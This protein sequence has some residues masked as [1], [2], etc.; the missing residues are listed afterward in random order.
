MEKETENLYLSIEESKKII[1]KTIK[2]GDMNKMQSIMGSILYDDSSFK[3]EKDG[4]D[5]Q[6]N[7]NLGKDYLEIKF[8]QFSE[9]FL[10]KNIV[11]IELLKDVVAIQN[12]YEPHLI[13]EDK[14][15]DYIEGDYT[16]LQDVESDRI[17]F[18]KQLKFLEQKGIVTEENTPMLINLKKDTEYDKIKLSE[19]EIYKYSVKHVINDRY[20][21]NGIFEE[22]TVEQNNKYKD[23][24]RA[25]IEKERDEY[26]TKKF[27]DALLEKGYSEMIFKDSDKPRRTSDNQLLDKFYETAYNFKQKGRSFIEDSSIVKMEQNYNIPEFSVY[28]REKNNNGIYFNDLHMLTRDP[29]YMEE[30]LKITAL[31][32]RSQGIKK[33]FIYTSAIL[34]NQDALHK[35]VYVKAQMKALLDHGEYS[36]DDIKVQKQHQDVYQELLNEYAEKRVSVFDVDKVIE[37]LKD[38]T[39]SKLDR[40]ILLKNLRSENFLN[41]HEQSEFLTKNNIVPEEYNAMLMKIEQGKDNLTEKEVLDLSTVV[42]YIDTMNSAIKKDLITST[43]SQDIRTNIEEPNQIIERLGKY[44]FTDNEENLIKNK[45]S[46]IHFKDFDGKKT[47]NGLNHDRDTISQLG[48]KIKTTKLGE[49]IKPELVDV[50]QRKKMLIDLYD[51]FPE[52]EFPKLTDQVKRDFVNVLS[53]DLPLIDKNNP[54]NINYKISAQTLQTIGDIIRE[55]KIFDIGNYLADRIDHDAL[56][57]VRENQQENKVVSPKD[58]IVHTEP[59]NDIDITKNG[60]EL[61]ENYDSGS[62]TQVKGEIPAQDDL[63]EPP[64][65]SQS[66]STVYKVEIPNNHDSEPN[67]FSNT[68][69]K[70]EQ[71]GTRTI[72]QKPKAHGG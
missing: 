55:Y 45:E 57:D 67:E 23:E 2:E 5:Y 49:K 6:L 50:I 42:E 1:N 54:K 22:Q 16:R 26:W 68:A 60:E 19:E 59:T 62:S 69:Y 61:H 3:Y 56:G 64:Y 38:G 13:K 41:G 63:I 29:Q 71:L 48:E 20:K 43:S 12:G 10:T 33:P 51:N 9:N 7:R 28:K 31:D 53:Q 21:N 58:L 17:S 8:R 34:N 66:K 44:M 27:R 30:I 15:I 47:S 40:F 14:I 24:N 70:Q 36:F 35:K 32:I 72:S 18:L 37:G 46:I 52:N 39:T 11:D 4:N 25:R 65:I